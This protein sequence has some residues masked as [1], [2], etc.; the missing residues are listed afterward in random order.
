MEN[1]PFELLDNIIGHIPKDDQKS[2]QS[3]SF[4]ARSWTYPC[5]RRLLETVNCPSEVALWSKLENSPPKNVGI[6]HHVRSLS[7][8]V[9]LSPYRRSEALARI[10]HIELPLFP[11]LRYMVLR[12]SGG[13]SALRQLGV[14]LASQDTLESLSLILCRVSTSALVALINHFP[15]LVHVRLVSLQYEPNGE[16]IPPLARP[17]QK[18]SVNYPGTYDDPGIIDQL[19]GLQPL[20]DEV[21]VEVRFRVA[22]LLAQRIIDG[23]RTTVKRL[24]LGIDKECKCRAETLSR[25]LLDG[26]LKLCCRS[27]QPFDTC[28]LPGALRTHVLFSE[29]HRARHNFDDRLPMHSKDYDR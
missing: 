28:Q 7:V 27:E 14:A 13:F 9:D 20:C 1:L 22:P 16:P 6:F 25:E 23:V 17:L 12:Y 19:L 3:C 11:Y 2:L 4:V 5:Q 21:T 8:G 26:S 29:I 15:N 10:P 18:L 24:N